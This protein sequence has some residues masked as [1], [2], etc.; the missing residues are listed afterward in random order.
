MAIPFS[1]GSTG[2]P[3]GIMLTHA[4]MTAAV[5]QFSAAIELDSETML[6][7]AFFYISGI[8]FSLVGV[9][10]SREYISR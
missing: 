3:K 7:G 2:Q 1:S 8:H 9:S 10:L 4:A 5:L 6:G